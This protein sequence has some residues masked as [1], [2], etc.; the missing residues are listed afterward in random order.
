MPNGFSLRRSTRMASSLVSAH[1]LSRANGN[2]G[3]SPMARVRLAAQRSTAA[4]T[5]VSE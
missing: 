2:S 5:P 3:R 1:A 4:A